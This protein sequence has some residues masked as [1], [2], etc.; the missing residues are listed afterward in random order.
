MIL[1]LMKRENASDFA[2]PENS[3]QQA[4]VLADPIEVVPDPVPVR[5]NSFPEEYP[6]RE[7][8][9][10]RGEIARQ[11]TMETLG[12][13]SSQSVEP[14]GYPISI[15]NTPAK[16]VIDLYGAVSQR[17]L[18]MGPQVQ[19]NARITVQEGDP[20]T[21]KERM[22]QAI[23]VALE[24]ENIV[25]QEAGEKFVFVFNPMVTRQIPELVV[26]DDVA[27]LRRAP[28]I[29]MENAR[30]DMLVEIYEQISGLRLESKP[31]LP[32][33]VTFTSRLPLTINEQ[34]AA[35]EACLGLHGFKFERR[36]ADSF[37]IESVRSR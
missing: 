16:S 27:G 36:G 19:F 14:K 25:L 29:Q 20:G 33:F 18:I 1:L 12:Q 8:L 21:S 31:S 3:E 28:S 2:T 32:P 10:Q 30:A 17:T 4:T 24:K 15:E 34:M 37:A 9:R 35:I 7:T 26:R 13:A 11:R 23:K 6:S 22:L 5:D